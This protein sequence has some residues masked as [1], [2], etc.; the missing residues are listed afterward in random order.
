MIDLNTKKIISAIKIID[1][2]AKIS[3]EKTIT[4]FIFEINDNSIY[5]KIVL[6]NQNI[7]IQF[8]ILMLEFKI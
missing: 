5:M 1:L 8:Q 2:N 7:I 3:I 6:I 4:I